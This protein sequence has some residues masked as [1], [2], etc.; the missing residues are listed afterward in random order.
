[1]LGKLIIVQYYITG[2]FNFMIINDGVYEQSFPYEVYVVT[3]VNEFS[4]ELQM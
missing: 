1:M 4:N 2:I 3:V